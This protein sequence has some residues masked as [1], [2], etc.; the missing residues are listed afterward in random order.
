[1]KQIDRRAVFAIAIVAGALLFA[2]GFALSRPAEQPESWKPAVEGLLAVPTPC[3]TKA[4]LW[5]DLEALSDDGQ[6]ARPA[7]AEE[8]A[9]WLNDWPYRGRDEQSPT[10]E[11]QLQRAAQNREV[12]CVGEASGPEIRPDGD[13]TETMN[14][15]HFRRECTFVKW[16]AWSAETADELLNERHTVSVDEEGFFHGR[17]DYWQ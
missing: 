17:V 6:R 16:K 7:S 15:I 12:R 1:M 10:D 13:D 8:A 11:G 5:D 9:D 3:C 4:S 14:A 2:L